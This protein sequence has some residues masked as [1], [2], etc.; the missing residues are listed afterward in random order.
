MFLFS[1]CSINSAEQNLETLRMSGEYDII[2]LRIYL[3]FN[4]WLAPS[5]G[6]AR[7]G[8]AN[9]PFGRRVYLPPN[10]EMSPAL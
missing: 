4:K 7:G 5:N 9:L 3:C 10:G 1:V 2:V 8:K 6:V